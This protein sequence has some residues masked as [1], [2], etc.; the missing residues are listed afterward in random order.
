MI[1]VDFHKPGYMPE[2]GLT[3]VIIGAR[4]RDQWVFIRHK[5]RKGYELPAGHIKDGEDPMEAASR[6]L[7]EETGA[8]SFKVEDLATYTVNDNGNTRAGRLFFARVCELGDEPD[9]DEVE[10]LIFSDDLPGE[11]NFHEVQ[12][13]LFKYLP[14]YIAPLLYFNLNTVG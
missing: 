6:E 7:R 11:L 13:V 14:V 4:Y 12:S 1:R 10:E 8:I 2:C 5:K 9:A 3:F